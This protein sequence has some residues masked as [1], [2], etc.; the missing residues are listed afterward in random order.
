MVDR[1]FTYADFSGFDHPWARGDSG[2][3]NAIVLVR[4]RRGHLYPD[5]AEYER[6][7]IGRSCISERDSRTR[8]EY[9]F[10]SHIEPDRRCSK[11][12]CSECHV[13]GWRDDYRALAGA[14]DLFAHGIGR[15]RHKHVHH[16]VHPSRSHRRIER[17]AGEQQRFPHC[18]GVGNG[19][20]GSHHSD[21]Q[22]RRL[23]LP[24]QAIRARP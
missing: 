8:Y 10:N 14:S 19:R 1:L 11:R 5:R 2:C 24:S 9:R 20:G 7:W 3:K 12:K 17:N 4:H 21:V 13:R 22:R 18:A 15:R 23:R 6:N 16:H